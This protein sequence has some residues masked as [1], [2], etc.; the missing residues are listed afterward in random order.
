MMID[1]VLGFLFS[2]DLNDVLLIEKQRP[3]W[4][5][6]LLNGIGGKVEKGEPFEIAMKREF[7]EESGL[8]V[9]TWHE[10]CTLVGAK[11]KIKCFSGA[12]DFYCKFTTTTD[13]Q[14][15]VRPTESLGERVVPNINWLI[16]MAKDF[17][18]TGGGFGG[19]IEYRLY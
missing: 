12:H 9:G 6:G 1:Y 17:Y 3:T 16:P 18:W 11:Y 14:V 7:L 2:P 8:W 19:K 15:V 5:K 13:E 4:Q 10:F